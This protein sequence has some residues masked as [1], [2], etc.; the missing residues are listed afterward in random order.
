M[1]SGIQSAHRCLEKKGLFMKLIDHLESSVPNPATGLSEE[2]FLWVSRLTP[3]VNVDLL[4][5]NEFGHT[6]L[7]WRDDAY[8]PAGW[9]VPGGIIRYKETF[10]ERINAVAE[11]ELGAEVEYDPSPLAINEVIQRER[12][13]R[14]HFVSLLYRCRLVSLLSE[15]LEFKGNLPKPGEWQWHKECPENIIAVHKMYQ[16]FI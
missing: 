11:V 6:L 3:I 4:V 16:K 10:A 1:K 12:A 2:L 14:G 13:D 9:H 7:T 8:Y 5:K 15:R